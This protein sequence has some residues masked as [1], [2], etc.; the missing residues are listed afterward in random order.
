MR[1]Y[2]LVKPG[3]LY[4]AQYAAAQVSAGNQIMGLCCLRIIGL[5]KGFICELVH[6]AIKGR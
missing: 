6:R 2:V 5:S 4:I 1:R 3:N